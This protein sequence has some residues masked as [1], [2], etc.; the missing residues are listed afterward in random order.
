ML[1]NLP[2]SVSLPL[3]VYRRCTL[4]PAFVLAV[5]CVGIASSPTF[6]L[7]GSS[8]RF[9]PLNGLLREDFLNTLPIFLY[10]SV[11]LVFLITFITKRQSFCLLIVRLII[12]R[13][14]H[15]ACLLHHS[16]P[17][18]PKLRGVHMPERFKAK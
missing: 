8:F 12:I 6:C 3:T 17:G 16:I 18:V 7:S 4:F 5:P 11:P 9:E 14:R 15:H 13:A 10:Q 1:F 2:Y